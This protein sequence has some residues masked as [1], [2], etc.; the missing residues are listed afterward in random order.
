MLLSMREV[1]QRGGNIEIEA[2]NQ[3]KLKAR[4]FGKFYENTGPQEH[5]L[6]S[7]PKY[8]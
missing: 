7:P 8:C 3:L 1:E 4:T 6:E 5:I 2:L